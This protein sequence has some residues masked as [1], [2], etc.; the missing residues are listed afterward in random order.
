MRY[1]RIYAED[2]GA[3]R[4]EDVELEG[5]ITHI[6]N[7]VPPLLVSGPYRCSEITFVEQRGDASNWE[8]HVAPRR[9]WLI[10]I[11]GRAVVTTSDGERREVGPGDV[12]LAEDTG[13]RGHLTMPLTEVFRFAM[14]PVAP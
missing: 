13:G 8:T 10:V 9:Q 12:V 1:L 3:S 11:S 6:V 2:G 14:I 5:T 7:G 4:F